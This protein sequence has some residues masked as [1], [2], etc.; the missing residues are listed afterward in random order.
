MD[1]Y[2]GMEARRSAG[3]RESNA[4]MGRGATAGWVKCPLCPSRRQK[5]FARG[6][7][8]QMHL[9]TA[10]GDASA[11]AKAQA[12]IAC[13]ASTAIA[14]SRASGD[15][16]AWAAAEAKKRVLPAACVAARDGDTATLRGLVG[17]DA[18]CASHRDCH[19]YRPHHWAAGSETGCLEWLLDACPAV[20]VDAVTSR[21]RREGKRGGRTVLHWACRNGVSKHVRL[22][23]ERRCDASDVDAATRAAKGRFR[24]TRTS[25][26]RDQVRQDTH[27]PY[28]TLKR[29]GDTPESGDPQLSTLSSR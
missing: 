23:L 25:L 20:A 8:L 7:G 24:G 2:S 13:E 29:D 18:T 19:G 5:R 22:L 15:G 16:G 27:S 17:F 26:F 21:E 9:D 6:R 1:S 12:V 3:G 11:E 4:M 14:S 10:H 28:E